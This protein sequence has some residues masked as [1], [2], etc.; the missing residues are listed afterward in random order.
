MALLGLQAGGLKGPGGPAS[1]VAHSCGW[2]ECSLLVGRS[3]PNPCAP[4]PKV[5]ECPPSVVAGSI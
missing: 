3:G 5:V 4:L 2:C 1:G